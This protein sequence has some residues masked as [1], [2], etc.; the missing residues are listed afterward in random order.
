M[1]NEE[2][3][4]IVESSDAFAL[5]IMN[6]DG[7]ARNSIYHS[8]FKI[9]NSKFLLSIPL[10]FFFRVFRGPLSPH[11]ESKIQNSKSKNLS[12]RSLSK[13]DSKSLLPLSSFALS[14]PFCGHHPGSQQSLAAKMHKRRKRGF[15]PLKENGI[16]GFR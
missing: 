16:L 3:N 2:E 5:G 13:P 9:H 12:R 15:E 11:S 4:A 6:G 8:K 14:A 10:L 1:L 7:I